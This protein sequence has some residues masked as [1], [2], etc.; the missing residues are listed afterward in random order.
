[1]TQFT[2]P[3]DPNAAL[4][5]NVI[6]N[7]QHPLP[8]TT[9]GYRTLFPTYA[10]FY[11]NKTFSIKVD[12]TP[13]AIGIDY[14]L[15]H[16]YFKAVERTGKLVYGGIWFINP[17]LVGNVKITYHTLGGN[18]AV[19]EERK[20]A[21][22][23]DQS[24]PQS[25]SWEEVQDTEVYFPA[26]DV[27]FD[28]TEKKG[29]EDVTSVVSEIATSIREKDRTQE[30]IYLLL[31]EWFLTLEEVVDASPISSHKNN[32]LNP[33]Q[34]NWYNAG[35]L[36]ETGITV[37]ASTAYGKSLAELTSHINA[38]GLTQSDLNQYV[39]LSGGNTLLGDVRLADGAMAIR[40]TDNDLPVARIN[41]SSG[42]IHL[43]VVGGGIIQADKHA[44]K[45][46]V[47]AELKAGPI[48]LQVVSTA[49]SQDDNSLL[50]NGKAIMHEGNI[51]DHLSEEASGYIQI[52]V[53]DTST[54]TISGKGMGYNPLEADAVLKQASGG[55]NG[56]AKGS[57][58]TNSSSDTVAAFSEASKQVNDEVA[59]KVDSGLKINNKAIDNDITIVPADIGLAA[60][61]NVA[62]ADMPVTDQHLTALEGKALVG[63][64]H[65]FSEMQ[66]PD[67]TES[68][69]GISIL[70]K[71][72]T[73]DDEALA[74]SEVKSYH[75]KIETL[76]E[77]AGSAVP[78]DAIDLTQY[79]GNNYLPI[80]VLGSY[81][82]S[83]SQS[84]QQGLGV[85]VERNGD[86]VILRNGEDVN[87]RGVFYAYGTLDSDGKIVSLTATA[88]RY[89]PSF[90]PS[91]AFVESVGRN[92]D[93]VMLSL[94]RKADDSLVVYATLLYNTMD[95]TR[96][97]GCEIVADLRTGVNDFHTHQIFVHDET[98]YILTT[99]K[100]TSTPFQVE[101]RSAPISAF[102]LDEVVTF[103]EL[104]ISGVDLYGDAVAAT[105]NYPLISSNNKWYSTEAEDKPFILVDEDYTSANAYHSSRQQT[106]LV[107][108]ANQM[109]VTVG[110][111]TV[112]WYST[113]V[114]TG[115]TAFSFVID[116]DT[117]VLT[118]DDNCR[119]PMVF[120]A[121]HKQSG[122]LYRNPSYLVSATGSGSWGSN[123]Y[124]GGFSF[125][126]HGSPNFAYRLISW[127]DTSGS[128]FDNA[129]INRGDMKYIDVTTVEGNFGSVVEG[130][131]YAVS[132]QP[133]KVIKF[134]QRSGAGAVKVAYSDEST[135]GTE[136]RDLG[137]TEDRTAINASVLY[138]DKHAITASDEDGNTWWA[139]ATVGDGILSVT[140]NPDTNETLTI[141]QTLLDE[142]K[143]AAAAIVAEPT[144]TGV[145]MGYLAVL[146]EHDNTAFFTLYLLAELATPSVLK[147][148]F[149][150]TF[151]L[152]V[153][154]VDDVV[155]GYSDLSV[156]ASI[157]VK[158]NATQFSTGSIN[159]CNSSGVLIRDDTYHMLLNTSPTIHY[160]G[161][162]AYYTSA[163]KYTIATG[164]SSQ[165][166]NYTYDDR[167]DAEGGL[168]VPGVGLVTLSTDTSQTAIMGTVNHPVTGWS[169]GEKILISSAQVVSGWNIY[170]TEEIGYF[171]QS[172]YFQMPVSAVDLKADFPETYK[173][174][175]FYIYASIE[176][177][178]PHYVVSEQYVT[179][180]STDTYIGT[181]KTGN[182]QI[183]TLEVERATRL[184]SFREME[185]HINSS[186][187]HGFDPSSATA[188]TLGLGLVENKPLRQT[189][190][191]TSFEEVFNSWYRLSHSPD[192]PRQ[193]PAIPEETEKWEYDEETDSIRNTTNSGSMVAM[194]SPEDNTVGDYDFETVVSSTSGDDDWIGVII[195]L[196]ERDGIEHTLS[197]LASATTTHTQHLTIG[198]NHRQ[199]ANEGNVT[200][201]TDTTD[202]VAGW[203]KFPERTIKVTRR[204][205]VFTIKV[206]TYQEMAIGPTPNR[207]SG[208][209]GP[210]PMVPA[211]LSGQQDL[212]WLAR[213]TAFFKAGTVTYNVLT[214]DNSYIYFDGVL[215]AS[216]TTGELVTGTLEVTEGDHDIAIM[217][218]ELSGWSY[219]LCNFTDGTN[220][221]DSDTTWKAAVYHGTFTGT[222]LDTADL[223]EVIHVIDVNDHDFL[224]MFKGAVRFGY[225]A[226][227]QPNSTW[228]N[229]LRPDEDGKNYYATQKL[230]T[231]TASWSNR[232]I[233]ATGFVWDTSVD[234]DGTFFFDVPIPEGAVGR[235]YL[236]QASYA[237]A[238]I[239]LSDDKGL[240]DARIS[241]Y[242]LDDFTIRFRG[243]KDIE[244][245]RLQYAITFYLDDRLVGF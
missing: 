36:A 162:A 222:N 194:M 223:E 147:Y 52:A 61:T 169:S 8:D 154:V 23:T 20:T 47:M 107:V 100:N 137:P 77:E 148:C 178:D 181:C 180:S 6:S 99:V 90:L 237:D 110:M 45:A 111:S 22:L 206:T 116:L 155:T 225:T 236:A 220:S 70:S 204:G 157:L 177:G 1:M 234:D 131:P 95:D 136:F 38:L 199:S 205:S 186:S 196:V 227:S 114:H 164:S 209:S 231:D 171:C 103:T 34:N 217:V 98:V 19:T 214:D 188:E 13:L 105:P 35:A 224:D 27:Q 26:V 195:A 37:D 203:N 74:F 190:V 146:T 11:D 12:D 163:V 183:L 78:A 232:A 41:M 240:T 185:E 219:A 144:D 184:G 39:K 50:I 230:L 43:D 192:F 17:N 211:S 138:E 228:K 59:G 71:D 242:K 14:Y 24:A 201:I 80:P 81:E 170:F 33:H 151:D 122:E 123:Y 18:T 120:S 96:H 174:N 134:L 193:Y 166:Y 28:R 152:K 133:G 125:T 10:P 210:L 135:Y 46:G 49:D 165:V 115:H 173:N 182:T 75:E 84:Q 238:G 129:D 126:A 179:D 87:T 89:N 53:E 79:G 25:S 145:H 73:K 128:D 245:S 101:L 112:G 197:V 32:E 16:K 143:A 233:H 198:Y 153:T 175:T 5:A 117:L 83:G 92:T 212:R 94:V 31:D 167:G 159:N 29:E 104:A 121:D 63:H 218:Q 113:G 40:F 172:I 88:T 109:R 241:S 102:K 48:T 176:G 221:Y 54:L 86:L 132:I 244:Y 91:G 30:D 202:I 118:P 65:D 85:L 213:K 208:M 235:A 187:P 62:D 106:G 93:D 97:L 127:E 158:S 150:T 76:E 207:I 130:I 215:I 191:S 64:T 108:Q 56:V 15:T 161:W 67:A 142:I 229:I 124:T 4:A 60:V 141:S 42:N 189:L 7:E 156:I 55:V 51:A 243:D 58:A 66:V 9:Q 149:K 226:L 168:L 82:A 200:I 140:R 119:P 239:S 216:P 57:T 68:V 2:Y 69:Y 3:F 139:G 72:L 21:Y 160:T 44:N